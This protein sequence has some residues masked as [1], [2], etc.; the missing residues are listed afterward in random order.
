MKDFKKRYASDCHSRDLRDDEHHH[1]TDTL[2]A[3][4]LAAQTFAGALIRAKITQ[5]VTLDLRDCWRVLVV[6]DCKRRKVH[7]GEEIAD[8]SL[9]AYLLPHV[10]PTCHGRGSAVIVGSP[11][12]SSAICGS[13]NGEGRIG[14]K[15]DLDM[16]D[17]VNYF[18]ER[19]N[20]TERHNTGS[21]NR[22]LGENT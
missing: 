6:D 7:F 17:E 12:L 14:P 13:C 11:I 16:K 19:L 10:C 2:A 3:V 8:L 1:S 15:F 20:S 9:A 4:A 18:I 22:K 21:A 5:N